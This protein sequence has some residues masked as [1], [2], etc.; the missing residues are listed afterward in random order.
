MATSPAPSA[1]GDVPVE[2]VMVVRRR[3]WRRRMTPWFFILPAVLL[4]IFVVGAPAVC[5]FFLSMTSWDG[6]TFGKFIGLSNFRDVVTSDNTV[7]PA[8][9]NNVRW[10]LI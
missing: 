7:V 5:T 10:T 2:T 9:L 4:H 1:G 6:F 3:S 8:M